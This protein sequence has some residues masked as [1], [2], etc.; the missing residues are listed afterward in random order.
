MNRNFAILL[1]KLLSKHEV[2]GQIET[3]DIERP[4]LRPIYVSWF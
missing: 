1:T 3:S 2:V 4:L